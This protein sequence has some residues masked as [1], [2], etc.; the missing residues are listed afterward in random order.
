MLE[1]RVTRGGFETIHGPKDGHG[2]VGMGMKME[3]EMGIGRKMMMMT[4]VVS[5]VLSMMCL[6]MVACVD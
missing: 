3:M 2:E 4:K 5:A 1:A 6:M